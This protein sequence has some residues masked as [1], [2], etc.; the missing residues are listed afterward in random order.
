MFIFLVAS[1]IFHS[2]CIKVCCTHR[3]EFS[4]PGVYYVEK[5]VGLALIRTERDLCKPNGVLFYVLAS[6]TL[7]TAGAQIILICFCLALFARLM[8]RCNIFKINILL[9][10]EAHFALYS[11]LAVHVSLIVAANL[12]PNLMLYDSRGAKSCGAPRAKFVFLFGAF[13]QAPVSNYILIFINRLTHL[14]IIAV[15]NT[16]IATVVQLIKILS[17]LLAV[18]NLMRAKHKQF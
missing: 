16:L 18:P 17:L 9:Q 4:T 14:S 8:C 11:P 15:Y 12:S 5:R 13:E 3:V 1:T 7:L 10:G 2:S 6:V